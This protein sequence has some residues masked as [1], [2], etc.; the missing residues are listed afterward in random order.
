M[1]CYL[2]GNDFIPGLLT[3]DIKRNGLD[4]IISSYEEVRKFILRFLFLGF[5]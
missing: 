3:T 4:K 2:V 1:L 5:Y